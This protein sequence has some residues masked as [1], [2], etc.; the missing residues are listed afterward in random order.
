MALG[1][2]FGGATPPCSAS[3]TSTNVGSGTYSFLN[4]TAGSNYTIST[5]GSSFNTQLTL[6]NYDGASG[7][8]SHIMGKTEVIVMV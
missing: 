3:F 7:D 2:G 4:L 8:P 6:Y 1:G 5:C